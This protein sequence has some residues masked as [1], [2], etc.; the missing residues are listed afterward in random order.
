MIIDKCVA[1]KNPAKWSQK[2]A[3][4]LQAL[5]SKFRKS[6]WWRQWRS[7]WLTTTQSPKP[8]SH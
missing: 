8:V 3:S 7:N 2:R 4:R 1:R 5:T 6:G